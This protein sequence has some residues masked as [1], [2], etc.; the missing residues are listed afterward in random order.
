MRGKLALR[1]L[2]FPPQSLQ[3][4]VGV[5]LSSV[6]TKQGEVG[7]RA[8]KVVPDLR[9]SG[10]TIQKSGGVL[11]EGW[12]NKDESCRMEHRQVVENPPHTGSQGK[13]R[14]ARL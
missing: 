7:A 3:G 9:D 14:D 4:D 12:G 11:R 5:A 8:M 13:H 1:G 6:D 2:S 10:V